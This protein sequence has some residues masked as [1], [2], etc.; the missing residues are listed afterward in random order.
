MEVKFAGLKA[1]M[2]KMGETNKDLAKLLE[3]SEPSVSR[4]L[5]R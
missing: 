1:E 4:R 3:I 5:S 2:A